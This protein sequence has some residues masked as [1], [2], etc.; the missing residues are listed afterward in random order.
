MIQV[1][2]LSKSFGNR[3][4]LN[5]FNLKIEK[6]QTTVI[7]GES[8]C[9]KTIFLKHLVGLLQADSGK[10]IFDGQRVDRMSKNKFSS[11]RKR[12]TLVFQ[13]STLFDWLSVYENIALPL[14]EQKNIT[15]KNIQA[16]VTKYLKI[17]GLT[18]E[19]NK[20]P[21]ELSLGMQKRVCI[22]RGLIMHPEYILFDE[23]TTGLDPIIANNI[24]ELFQKLK[25]LNTTIL[26]VSHDISTVLKIADKI[27][28]MKNGRII[29]A[30]SVDDFEN[31]AKSYIRDFHLR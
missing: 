11:I 13:K 16:E 19:E 5:G 14:R 10:I 2:N 21:D 3:K 4:I 20:M 25:K 29:F 31:S 17:V 27:A 6:G 30:G 15:E 12:I 8:G 26:I 7:L 23:P 1:K 22:A 9:G 28:M 18:G 24:I